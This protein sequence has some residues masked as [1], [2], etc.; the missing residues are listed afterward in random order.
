[1]TTTAAI[2]RDSLIE[3]LDAIL[4]AEGLLID[5]ES[6]RLH[7]ADLYS[8][9]GL[10]AA[11]I[12]PDSI[13]QLSAAA[14]EIAKAGLALLPRGGG[15]TYV[16]GYVS[17]TEGAVAVDLRRMNK[18][19]EINAQDMLI[20]VEAGVTWMAIHE[21]LKPLGLRLP[22][23]GTFSGRGATV[24]G[25]LSNGALFLGTARYGTSAEIVLGLQVVLAD[26]SILH[27]GQTAISTAT[28]PFSRTFGPD[29]TGL[30][31]HDAG[32]MGIKGQLTFRMMR[33]PAHT[34]YLSFGFQD[35]DAGVE[36]ICEIGRC[37]LA[38]D[39]FM[40]DPDKTRQ[41]LAT[42]SD[43]VKDAKTLMKVVTQERGLLRGLKAGAQLAMAGR[44]F[45]DDGCYSLHIV[46]AGRSRE[47]VDGDM[48]L[49][50]AIVAKLGGKELPNSIPRAGRADPFSQLDAVLGATGDR[51]I[52]LNA[53]VAHSD[54]HKL[55]DAVEA[56]IARH[57]SDLDAAGVI[58]SRL[59]TVI[60]SHVFSY[61]PVF[62][63]HDSWL[64]MH[65]AMV[66]AETKAKTAE[67]VPNPQARALVMKVRGEIVEL[68]AAFGAQSNQIGR[69]YHYAD[70][71]RPESRLL[72]EG[73]KHLLD[74]EGRINPGA[75]GLAA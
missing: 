44:D 61:E 13:E 23:F 16:Q 18:I 50:R 31:V 57:Q 56:L 21:A 35:R 28:R 66:S 30:F 6:R 34:D 26:G 25:G 24:G 58:V 45:I 70:I 40:M 43:L 59:L 37:E 64:P 74:P 67:P 55:V 68:F 73:V 15:L 36:A 47:A 71:M 8:A 72:I 53:K 65:H 3:S 2:T 75:L 9:S 22:F 20:T 69:T 33:T 4:G 10:V 39:A 12:R 52:A 17:P 46:L 62:N 48:A 63:W 14:K 54:A 60:G 1:M 42:P 5:M 49:A 38:E 7:S 32:A 27:T 41:A 19:I 11:V 51:W 29:T